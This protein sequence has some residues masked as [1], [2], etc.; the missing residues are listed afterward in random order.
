MAKQVPIED[1]L[2]YC[3]S[4]PDNLSDTALLSRFPE[5]QEQLGPLLAL[6]THVTAVSAPP[7]P[8]ERR[9]AM[10]GRIMAAAAARQG[11]QPLPVARPVKPLPGKGWSWPALW[12]GRLR[13][14][15][16]ASG[17]A[18]ALVII[19]SWW[20]AAHSLPDSPFYDVK[21]ASERLIVNFTPNAAD[22]LRAH[23]AITSARLG[24][25]QTMA[26][27]GKLDRA[28]KALESYQEHVIGGMNALE[29]IKGDERTEL[30]ET[31][32]TSTVAGSRIIE[33]LKS[34]PGLEVPA[35]GNIERIL[36]S[37][38]MTTQ[39]VAQVLRSGGVDPA[40]LAIPPISNPV[41][42]A[43]PLAGTQ[44]AA[45][46]AVTATQPQA[47]AQT[48]QPGKPTSV[49]VVASSTDT[50]ISAQAS[51][52]SGNPKAV[53]G[54][55]NSKT[56]TV[57]TRVVIAAPA[58]QLRASVSPTKTGSPSPSVSP[59]RLITATITL[60]A[61]GVPSTYTHTPTLAPA[62]TNTAVIATRTSP[63]VRSSHTPVP[64]AQTHIPPTRTP[65]PPTQT[66]V[67][68][69]RVP[70]TFTE[71]PTS[72]PKPA[73]T[74]VPLTSTRVPVLTATSVPPTSTRRPTATNVPPTNTPVPI[75]TV[76]VC[77][78]EVTDISTACVSSTCVNWTAQINNDGAE[79]IGASWTAS[80]LI[81]QGS[82]G[83]HVVS[84]LRGATQFAPGESSVGDTFCYDFPPD[85]DHYK[86]RFAIDSSGSGCSPQ[87]TSGANSPCTGPDS[88][89]TPQPTPIPSNTHEPTNTRAPT[90]TRQPTRTPRSGPTA[91]PGG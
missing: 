37:V 3:L 1:A 20:A 66:R 13:S 8:V 7:V 74:P 64:P 11:A 9:A 61:T 43:T 33:T 82:G 89:A 51:A 88:T 69:T 46:G 24:D 32:Y 45:L 48:Q 29:E 19:F 54:G 83:Y 50:A 77:D 57:P 56:K 80:L 14:I 63:P 44:V 15:A 68:P 26:A 36:A 12:G 60:T 47:Q 35:Q 21:L 39:E 4:N 85:A 79:V 52:T 27:A 62:P 17:V 78:L 22:R 38:K 5:Y 23:E 90:N 16:W 40:T 84:T 34:A 18:V 25:A 67:P 41:I 91:A 10:K 86:V 55:G 53:G 76:N 42:A 28:G 31:L 6:A 87:N 30:A 49:A 81:K 71:Q 72:T 70:P 65:L 73:L 58:T 2:D 59:T 75:P